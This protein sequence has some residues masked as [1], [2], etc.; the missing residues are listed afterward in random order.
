MI[1]HGELKFVRKAADFTRGRI[2][3]EWFGERCPF[4]LF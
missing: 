3:N 1:Q 4:E 2:R